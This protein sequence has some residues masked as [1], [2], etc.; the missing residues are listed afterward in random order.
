MEKSILR[1]AFLIACLCFLTAWTGDP[2]LGDSQSAAPPLPAS[3]AVG[4][5]S[6][7]GSMPVSFIPN[8]GQLDERVSYCVQGKDKAIYFSTEGVTFALTSID[9]DNQG[10]RENLAHNVPVLSGLQLEQRTTEGSRWAVKMD[11]LGANPDVKPIG[12]E[13]SG[14]VIS[15][16][17]GNPGNWKTGLPAYARIVYRDLWPGIDLVYSGT[18]EALKSE[19]II[20]PGADPSRIRLAYRGASSVLIDDAG[21]LVISTPSGKFADGAPLA[22]QEISGR[23]VAV[24]AA[25]QI[26]DSGGGSAPDNCSG[27]EHGGAVIHGF[28][29]GQYDRGQSLILDPVIQMY[30]GYIGG[31]GHDYGYAIAADSQGNAYITGYTYSASGFPVMAGPDLTFNG[32]DVD[33]YVAKVNASGTELE[34]CGYIGGSG[35]DYG[36]GIAVDAL[37]NSYVTGYTS[38]NEASFP[39]RT[40]PDLIHNGL[41]DVFVAKVNASGTGLQYC[42][43]IG[44]SADDYGR[45]IAVDGSGSAYIAGSTYS[46]ASG[47]PVVAGPQLAAG[48]G[49]DAFLAK[50]DAAGTALEYCGFIGGI[51]EDAASGIA[52]D[53]SGNAY[54]TGYTN[55]P[56]SATPAFP[57]TTGPFLEYK[58]GY[59]AFVAEVKPDGSGFVYCSY[60]GGLADDFGYGI[61]LDPWGSAYITGYTSSDENSFPVSAGP[62]LSHNGSYYDAFVAKISPGG[63]SLAYCGFIGGSEYDA[64]TGIAVDEWG[65]AYVTGYTSS[66]EESFPVKEG[67]SLTA[68]GSFDAYVARVDASG[69]YLSFCGYVGGADAD[70]GTG[71]ALDRTGSGNVYLTGNTYSTELS[72][73]AMEGPDLTHNGGRDGFAVKIYENLITLVQPDGYEVWYS[74]LEE[75]IIWQTTGEVEEV[76]IEYSTDNGTTWLEVVAATENEGVYTWLVP[77][78]ASTGCLVRISDAAD[79]A[80]SDT[81]DVAFTIIDEPVIF[82][83]SPNGGESWP[84]GSEQKITW[85]SAGVGN[86]KLEYTSDA[87]ATWTEIEAEIE[88]TGTYTWRVPDAVSDQCRVRISEADDMIPVDMS[89]GLF[90]IVEATGSTAVKPDTTHLIKRRPVKK[91]SLR[92]ANQGGWN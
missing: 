50:V 15:Y 82:V 54:L 52:V 12:T 58:G 41:F 65:Y 28:T 9:P 53:D 61:S 62:D 8:R 88:N 13:E 43:Y 60:I 36:Y 16:F 29:I 27:Q 20:H 66:D 40:G 84:V 76:K 83:I 23:R 59:E 71:I 42:G 90:S 87:S 45:G 18:M 85:R 6:D 37:G 35:N 11:F 89:D 56:P 64:G 69:R 44:G 39:V 31:P 24:P 3:G 67:P 68:A 19:F 70:L 17:H 55:S 46:A 72:F 22:Y 73:P 77:S 75:E 7:L 80:P 4:V 92:P 33:A 63:A 21:R 5:R 78:S 79:D 14:A 49:R 32:D 1:H 86:V 38:S 30:G 51:G 48:G 91:F 2:C 25:Y 47:F 26:Q 57:V 34:Y 74:G 10:H 81:S